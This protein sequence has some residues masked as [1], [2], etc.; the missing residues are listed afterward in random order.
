MKKSEFIRSAPSGPKYWDTTGKNAAE[1]IQSDNY[2]KIFL[3]DHITKC[4]G[5]IF[6]V[7][8]AKEI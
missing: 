4:D 2:V 6:F 3:P 5:L 1:K 7:V 8:A